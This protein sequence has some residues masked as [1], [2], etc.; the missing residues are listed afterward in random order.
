MSVSIGT[1]TSYQKNLIWKDG[2]IHCTV[3]KSC[4][5]FSWATLKSRLKEG[6]EKKVQCCCCFSKVFF[7]IKKNR[8]EQE[9][10]AIKLSRRMKMSGAN[11]WQSH[12]CC[13]QRTD[14]FAA[15]NFFFSAC[16]VRRSFE[17][18]KVPV[19]GNT[20]CRVFK[21]GIQNWERFLPKNQHTQRKLLNFENKCSGE[22][23][24]SAK[25]WLSSQFSM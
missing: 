14:C 9:N 15:T 13:W 6:I 18:A 4:S 1:H 19:Y 17:I 23:S 24:K 25:I 10:S 5:L 16:K 7:W 20:G 2:Y 3:G 22:V 11:V 8:E 21:E 12:L